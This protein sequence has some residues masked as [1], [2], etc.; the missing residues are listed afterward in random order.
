MKRFTSLFFYFVAAV[1]F[2]QSVAAQDSSV[3]NKNDVFDPTFLSVGGTEFRSADGAPG[4]KYWQ[5]SA[6]YNIHAT[7]D[8]KDTTLK[9]NVTIN[10]TNNS[11]DELKYL[12]L[13]L[14]QNL[15]NPS[16]RGAATT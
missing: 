6:N 7:L 3:Y 16:S 8:E 10:Y 12:W 14:D 13:Q 11:P 9:G 5:N 15:F 4:P 2:S 1:I